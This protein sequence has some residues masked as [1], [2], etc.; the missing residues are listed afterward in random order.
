MR[1]KPLIDIQGGTFAYGGEAAVTNRH[2]P[3]IQVHSD[4]QLTD[5]HVPGA[6][7]AAVHNGANLT[8]RDSTNTTPG[9]A[10]VMEKAGDVSVQRFTSK[11]T[12]IG[13][14]GSYSENWKRI[15][16]KKG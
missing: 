9:H 13:W 4:A 14:T 15:F 2:I 3:A 7:F 1:K 8:I 5:M 10:V 6:P 16:G 11:R 12:S